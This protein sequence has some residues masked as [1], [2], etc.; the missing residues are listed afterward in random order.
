MGLTIEVIGYKGVV[1]GATYNWLKAMKNPA[2]KVVG[3]DNGDKIAKMRERDSILSYVCVPEDNVLEVCKSIDYADLIVIRSTVTPDICYKAMKETGTHVCHLPEF[4]VE[5]TSIIDE[6]N[7]DYLVLGACCDDHAEALQHIYEPYISLVVTSIETSTMLKLAKNSYL[8]CLISFWNEIEAIAK[9]ANTNGHRIGSLACLD[10]RVSP[11][12]AKYHHK[13]G[14]KCLPKDLAQLT[15]F[16]N[17][18]GLKTPMLNAI[19]E[20]NECQ[21]S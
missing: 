11:Y 17:S 15:K 13:Y 3:R 20:V 8:A 1:G 7:Q 16:A 6:F 14:G 5:A 12:G 4:L 19:K 18:R 9:L 10:D 2:V 21:K